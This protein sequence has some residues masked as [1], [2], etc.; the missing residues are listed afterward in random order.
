MRL[1]EGGGGWDSALGTAP[2]EWAV[3]TGVRMWGVVV[4]GL[5]PVREVR[6]LGALPS[7]PDVRPGDKPG[8]KPGDRDNDSWEGED[9]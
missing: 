1:A 9:D 3:T 8:D 2:P 6:E 5:I 4:M 7:S